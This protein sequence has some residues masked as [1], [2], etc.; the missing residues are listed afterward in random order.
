M[1]KQT[2]TTR[3]RQPST[4]IYTDGVD[5]I[6]VKLRTEQVKQGLSDYALGLA[7]GIGPSKL[8][9]TWKGTGATLKTIRAI[10]DHLRVKNPK[11]TLRDP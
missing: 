1:S 9:K 4:T 8:G 5:P 3:G 2:I 11:F 7:T 6:I 10:L